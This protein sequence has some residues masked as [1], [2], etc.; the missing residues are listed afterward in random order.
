MDH[1]QLDVHGNLWTDLDLGTGVHAFDNN[2]RGSTMDEVYWNV[3]AT[4]DLTYPP[5][6]LKNIVVGLQGTGPEIQG[7]NAPW[8]EVVNPAELKPK[9]LFHAQLAKRIGVAKARAVLGN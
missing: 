5:P 6:G 9:N 2:A 7:T 8:V 4:K 3:R 1:H